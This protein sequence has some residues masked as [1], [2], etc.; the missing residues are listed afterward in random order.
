MNNNMTNKIFIFY[1]NFNDFY[2]V[3]NFI[4][5]LTSFCLCTSPSI[6]A[7]VLTMWIKL[8]LLFHAVSDFI[9]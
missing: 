7:K 6:T 9:V 4:E 1:N 5:E 3:A 2:F 8:S